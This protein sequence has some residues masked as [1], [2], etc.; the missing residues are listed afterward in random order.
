VHELNNPIGIISSRIELMLM[1]LEGQNLPSQLRE[2]LL[3]LERN[4]QRVARIA[5]GLLSFARKSPGD[6][7]PL[8]LNKVVDETLLLAR[9]QMSQEG[10]QIQATLDR[11]LPPLL[12][13]AN[14]LQQVVLNLITNSREAMPDGGTIAIETGPAPGR[15]GWVRLVVADNG[16]GIPPELVSKIFDPFYTTK[17]EGT[18]LGL[19]V[20]YGIIRDHRGLV[21]VQSEPGKGSTFILT[22]PV[23]EGHAP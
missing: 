13:D 18:G 19:S 15:P 8:D 21:D 23:A 14:A 5:R 16:P 22:F 3:V 7:V 1:E 4:A 20:S 2:D 11:F 12:G 6:R 10:I 9:K 17:A